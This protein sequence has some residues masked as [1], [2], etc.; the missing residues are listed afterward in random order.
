MN[1]HGAWKETQYGKV[2]WKNAS[3]FEVERLP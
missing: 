2:T 1:E 3:D